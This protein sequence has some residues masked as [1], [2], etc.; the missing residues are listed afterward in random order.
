MRRGPVF[1]FRKNRP[2]MGS[3]QSHQPD[4]INE[5][6]QPTE[7]MPVV[8]PMPGTGFL[9]PQGAQGRE[10]GAGL[11]DWPTVPGGPNG[12]PT[13]AEGNI[14]VPQPHE[15][16]FP[17]RDVPYTV[18]AGAPYAA[19]QGQVYP[20]APPAP[21]YAYPAYPLAPPVTDK[22]GRPPAGAQPGHPW[23]EPR[24]GRRKRARQSL[25]PV[26]LGLFFVLVQLLLL[27]RFVMVLLRLPASIA[28][29]GITYALSSL[30][31][32]PFS[33]LQQHFTPPLPAFPASIELFTLLAILTY[34]L[35]SRILVRICK[36]LMH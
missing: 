27:A 12:I 26:L 25:L 2:M 35:L 30:F 36:A 13:A 16:P 15:H 4:E 17:Y 18:A 22:N 32:F 20:F 28:W 9:S 29:I 19:G 8:S 7:P 21:N 34:G 23:D 11:S 14:P 6:D 33:L 5:H 24:S 1:D 10:G 31:V 3:Q